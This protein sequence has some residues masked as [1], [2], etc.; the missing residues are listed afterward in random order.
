MADGIGVDQDVVKDEHLRLIG[1][2]FLG[3]GQAEAK[4]ELF[5]GTL[6]QAVE[7]VGRITCAPDAG[8]LEVFI[9]KDFAV[10]DAS[11]FREG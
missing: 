11:E 2:E 4:E 3:D 9:Q 6:G 10:A 7:G 1:G 5:L 8:N